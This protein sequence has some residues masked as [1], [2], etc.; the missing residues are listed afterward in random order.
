[1][2]VKLYSNCGLVNVNVPVRP[3]SI[4]CMLIPSGKGVS[5]I[6]PFSSHMTGLFPCELMHVKVVLLL[7]AA[8]K[9]PFGNSFTRNEMHYHTISIGVGS[10]LVLQYTLHAVQGIINLLHSKSQSLNIRH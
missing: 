2:V 10:M 4:F 9:D 6:D 1:M 7:M 8:T 5:S 3:F